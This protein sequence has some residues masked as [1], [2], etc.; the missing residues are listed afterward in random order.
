MAEYL[1]ISPRSY[2]DLEHSRYGCSGTTLFF[3][4]LMLDIEALVRL[5]NDF[6]EQLERVDRHD[7]A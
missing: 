5:V 2:I 4:F 7:A 3:F 1:R 6:R